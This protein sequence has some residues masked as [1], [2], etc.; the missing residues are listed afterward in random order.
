[1]DNK[2]KNF[3]KFIQK[4]EMASAYGEINILKTEKICL[5]CDHRLHNMCRELNINLHKDIDIS[6]YD[7]GC[8]RYK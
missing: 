6:I 1:M 3:E 5:N 7:F 2:D 8:S 4:I